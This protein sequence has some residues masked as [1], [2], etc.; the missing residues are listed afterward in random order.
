MAFLTLFL[1]G[2]ALNLTPCVYPII[3]IT[4][5]FFVKQ[6]A[7]QGKARLSRAASHGD[8]DE[9][10]KEASRFLALKLDLTSLDP[11]AEAARAKERFQIK[12]V[13]TI[14]FLNAEGNEHANLKLT[15]FEKAGP[16]LERMKQVPRRFPERE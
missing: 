7:A 2:L 6:S 3:P 8:N 13:P 10:K 11:N 12:G 1:A 9:V 4:I 5:G 16:F 15:G 14:V